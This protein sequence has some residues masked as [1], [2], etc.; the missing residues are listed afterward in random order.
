MK[1]R[2]EWLP[3]KGHPPA[4]LDAYPIIEARL[5]NGAIVKAEAY[6]LD[7]DDLWVIDQTM[8]DIMEYRGIDL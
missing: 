8:H 6:D 7:N 1:A 2:T 4:A 3:N 5:R